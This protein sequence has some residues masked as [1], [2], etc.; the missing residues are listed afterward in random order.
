MD[1]DEPDSQDPRIR[2]TRSQVLLTARDLLTVGGADAV[3]FSA[4]SSRTGLSR[5]TLY[6]HWPTRERL[7]A[8][9]LLDQLDV[10]APPATGD[11]AKRVFQWLASLR[12]SLQP[13][14]SNG[15]ALAAVAMDARRDEGSRDAIQELLN[16]RH[17]ALDGH[18]AELR[19]PLSENEWAQLVGPIYFRRF[20][21]MQPV[22]DAFLRTL[23]SSVAATAPAPTRAA[24]LPRPRRTRATPQ[25]A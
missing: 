19:G 4:L 24:R 23:A 21:S 10:E 5:Q 8:A 11:L 16:Q 15:D 12:D 3:T 20:V 9:L 6:N 22:D 7:L 13:P 17:V 25:P 1:A 18:I 14:S 2:R